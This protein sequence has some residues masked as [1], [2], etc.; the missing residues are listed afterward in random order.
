MVMMISVV[1][2]ADAGKTTLIEKLVPELKKRGYHVGTIKHAVHESSL[3]TQGKDSW[4]H[5]LAGADTVVVSSS[6]K[7]ALIKKRHTPPKDIQSELSELEVYFSGMDIV[8]AEGYKNSRIPKIE[9]FRSGIHDAP[10]CA[11]ESMLIAMVTDADVRCDV[12]K[13]SL[14]EIP[15]LAD[16]IERKYLKHKI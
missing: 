10:L 1:G 13:F 15:G 9:I 7:I 4:R 2:Y 16:L 5:Y 6:E 12:P 14:D 8:F 3:D 11:R